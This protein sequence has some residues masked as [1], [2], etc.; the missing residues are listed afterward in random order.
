MEQVQL[1]LSEGGE[2]T[3]LVA[4][5]KSDNLNGALALNEQIAGE[6]PFATLVEAWFVGKIEA[7]WGSYGESG[8]RSAWERAKASAEPWLKEV[9]AQ[10]DADCAAF[11]GRERLAALDARLS[12]AK[13]RIGEARAK[14][15][16]LE[17]QLEATKVPAEP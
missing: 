5:I 14:V 11:R 12:R 17:G 9:G 10:C 4:L 16:Q 1:K 6:M 2:A 7:E 13:P 3:Q 8:A 15:E